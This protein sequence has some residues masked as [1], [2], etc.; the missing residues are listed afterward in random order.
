MLAKHPVRTVK[1]L[2]DECLSQL[3][4]TFDETAR[5]SVKAQLLDEPPTAKAFSP[6]P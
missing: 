3:S 4:S 2:A 5:A 1:K 6:D